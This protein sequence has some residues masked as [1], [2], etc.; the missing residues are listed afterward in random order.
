MNIN[1]ILNSHPR[2]IINSENPKYLLKNELEF[3]V[4]NL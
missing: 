2:V 4:S 3:N 1:Q